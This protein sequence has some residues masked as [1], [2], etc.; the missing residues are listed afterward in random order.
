LPRTKNVRLYNPVFL[1]M[2]VLD[3]ISLDV[4]PSESE[5]SP[6]KRMRLGFREAI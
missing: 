6:L 4:V 1:N 5:M 3:V 2:V